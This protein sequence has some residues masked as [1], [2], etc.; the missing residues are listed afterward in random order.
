LLIL[1]SD[2]NSSRRHRHRLISERLENWARYNNRNAHVLESA[3]ISDP[4][5]DTL[6]AAQNLLVQRH[7]GL[8]RS[9]TLNSR[10][11]SQLARCSERAPAILERLQDSVD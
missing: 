11:P 10:I 4:R 8:Y 2:D 1:N 6:K 9:L 5:S 7:L 3:N